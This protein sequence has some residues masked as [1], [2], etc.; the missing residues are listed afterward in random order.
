M[1]WQ[2]NAYIDTNTGQAPLEDTFSK[3]TWSRAHL[4]RRTAVFYD[5]SRRSGGPLSL[6]LLVN[7]DGSMAELLPPP[8]TATLPSTRWHLERST[9]ADAGHAP[10]LVR[11]IEDGPFY[12][13]SLIASHLGGEIAEVMQES[14]SLDRLRQP[15]IRTMVPYRNPRALKF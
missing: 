9:R 14:L 8:P 12:A 1:R 2:G 6:A 15:W 7:E 13:R 10:Q 5:I 4:Q 3:W 11:T